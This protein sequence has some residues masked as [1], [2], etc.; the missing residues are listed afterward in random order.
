[1]YEIANAEDQLGLLQIIMNN[2]W[3]A[4]SQQASTQ[5]KQKAAEAIK[6]KAKA[7][8]SKAPKPKAVKLPQRPTPSP[9]PQ[10]ARSMQSVV[11]KPT[12][13][14]PAPQ[15]KTIAP[16]KPKSPTITTRSPEEQRM[17]Q[18]YL[19]GETPKPL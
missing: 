4:I 9:V 1:M 5:A 17:F 10:Q 7:K 2:T 14:K 13:T 8:A 19:K 16:S 12:V 6:P 15:S 18:A 3:S 11:T